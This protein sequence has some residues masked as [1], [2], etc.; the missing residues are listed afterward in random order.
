MWWR[1]VKRTT[2]SC[3]SPGDSSSVILSRA[4]R[5]TDRSS[6]DFVRSSN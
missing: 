5:A 4:R 2:R 6:A 1:S 3:D